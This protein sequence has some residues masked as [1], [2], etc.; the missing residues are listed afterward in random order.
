M[1]DQQFTCH[2]Y[3][4]NKL[5]TLSDMAEDSAVFTKNGLDLQAVLIKIYPNGKKLFFLQDRLMVTDSQNKE[6][7]SKDCFD[8]FPL[9]LCW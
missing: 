1:L 5:K 4:Q 2:R 7:E 6:L 9:H 8:I 3:W